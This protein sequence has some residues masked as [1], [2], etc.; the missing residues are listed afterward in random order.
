M[1][2]AIK[3]PLLRAPNRSTFM[4]VGLYGMLLFGSIFAGL[5]AAYLPWW[6]VFAACVFPLFLVLA[7]VFPQIASILVI[8]AIAGVVPEFLL[9]QISVGIG[10]ILPQDLFLVALLGLAL[11]KNLGAKKIGPLRKGGI[12]GYL[13]IAMVTCAAFGVAIGVGLYGAGVKDAI[14]EF[15]NQIYWLVF[16]LPVAFVHTERDLR[17]MATAL[18]LLGLWIAIAVLIQFQFG[19]ALLTNARVE[20]LATG[21]IRYTDIIRSTAGGGIYWVI[22]ALF[23]SVARVL[24]RSGSTVWALIIA[25]IC[26]GAILVS[27]GRGIWIASFIALLL[28]ARSIGGNKAVL[29]AMLFSLLATA[30]AIVPLTILKP[31]FFDA[32]SER[33]ISTKDEGGQKSSLGWRLEENSFAFK[34]IIRNPLTGTGLGVAYKPKLDRMASIDQVRYIHNS[35]LGLWMKMGLASLLVAGWFAWKTLRTANDAVKRNRTATNLELVAAAG[36]AFVVPLITG[37]TQ[38]EWLV[39]TGISFFAMMSGL[40]MA[41]SN[42]HTPV[43]TP[44]A[45]AK[46]L[47]RS[48]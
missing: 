33:V 31:A 28:L 48:R 5:V 44:H 36:A 47:Y 32:V 18:V 21:S 35:Y 9:P 7:A 8:A 30:V 37:V 34:Q 6:F 46:D 23:I 20:D 10:R 24:K 11:L 15:R 1:K 19:I 26:A 40:T 43:S 13:M 14:S 25:I 22:F 2:S 38:P 41:F 42:L 39:A 12:L 3:I 29:A 16:F 17:L 27:F 45:R 4:G